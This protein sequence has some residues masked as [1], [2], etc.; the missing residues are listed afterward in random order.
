M[1]R[2]IIILIFGVLLHNGTYAKKSDNDSIYR[3]LCLFLVEKNVITNQ[4]I[5]D[6]KYDY[7]S[8]IAIWDILEDDD[9]PSKKPELSKKEFGIYQFDFTGSGSSNYYFVLI[10]YKSICKVFLLSDI[11]LIIYEL[12]DIKEKDNNVFDD[13]LFCRYLKELTK[14]RE[15]I[16]LL[17]KIGNLQYIYK[18]L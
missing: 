1:K 8:I 14:P 3:D 6:W 18:F 5:A 10:K 16:I 9:H 2:T 7:K 11:S 12:S 4:L 17:E 13:K 15:N